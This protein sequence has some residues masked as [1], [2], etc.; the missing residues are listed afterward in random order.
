MQTKDQQNEAQVIVTNRRAT[1][2]FFILDTIEAG[3]VLTGTEVKALR[4]KRGNLNDSYCVIEENEV[5]VKH[6]HIS[7]YEFGNI[8]NHEPLRD[9][10]LLLQ[11]K[12]IKWLIGQ[13]QRKGF[14]VIPLK[15]YFN[16]K[17]FIKLLL[18]IAQGKKVYD[19][20]EDIKKRESDRQIRR[21]LRSRQ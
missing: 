4:D 5:F 10:K 14:T 19:K 12:E 21:A 6:M 7:P 9:R 11:R 3:M 18:G 16:K 8:Y 20:R 13:T 1:H 15:L 17:G 2:D